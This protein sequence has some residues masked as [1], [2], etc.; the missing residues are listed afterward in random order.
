M[1]S[2]GDTLKTAREAKKASLEQV[3]Q[4]TNIAIHYL[5]AFEAEDFEGF[6]G[7][8]YL[9]GFLR[10]YAEYLGLD[11]EKVLA[12]YR[13]IKIQEAPVPVTELLH[14]GPPVSKILILAGAAV[15]VVGLVTLII[16]AALNHPK[17][18]APAQA[19]SQVYTPKDFILDSDLFEQRLHLGD[20]V[21]L[22]PSA[23]NTAPA[24]KAADDTAS[25]SAQPGNE[26]QPSPANQAKSLRFSL[27]AIG[28]TVS[29]NTPEG[30]K[31]LDMNVPLKFSL[32]D[33]RSLIITAEDF[34]KGN[35]AAGALLRF[36]IQTAAPAQVPVAAA[37]STGSP[38][39]TETAKVPASALAQPIYSSTTGS[40]YP[41]T[42]QISFQGYCMF[43]WQILNEAD[44]SG[45]NEQYFQKGNELSIQA[46][47]GVRIWASNAAAASVQVIVGGR[48]FNQ[49]LGGAG[50]V[51]V[52]DIRWVRDNGQYRLVMSPLE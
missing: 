7:E 30:Q 36:E 22:T 20:A 8:S 40:A 10:N 1:D 45:R 19:I 39:S 6:P 35:S 37:A 3:S 52:V 9:Q 46:N 2:L 28:D 50:D 49:S 44:R 24:D 27:T 16:L 48:T 11:P 26:A 33:G 14:R 23:P 42:L 4:D 47:N 38:T 41:F 12:N 21:V 34:V 31:N 25:T 43:R 51:I 5:E 15:V 29:L 17:T 13:A 18:K 32:A